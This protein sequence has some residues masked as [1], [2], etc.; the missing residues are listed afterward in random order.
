MSGFNN[1]QDPKQF[2]PEIVKK[3]ESF[4]QGSSIDLF[5]QNDIDK[6]TFIHCLILALIKL[7]YASS[8]QE[9]GRKRMLDGLG[10]DLDKYSRV[11]KEHNRH[12]IMDENEDEDEELLRLHTKFLNELSAKAMSFGMDEDGS[13]VV[14]DQ[15]NKLLSQ[16]DLKY[17]PDDTN[18]SKRTRKP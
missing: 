14:K 4:L 15:L 17:A 9:S 11:T 13:R 3:I 5:T 7:E 1:N 6:G 18:K 2:D 16:A 10:M 8:L 12:K